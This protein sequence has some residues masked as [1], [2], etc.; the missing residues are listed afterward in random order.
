VQTCAQV[1]GK[2]GRVGRDTATPTGGAGAFGAALRQMRQARGLT[3]ATVARQAACSLSLIR[4]V[5]TG[6]RTIHSWLA[7]C[8]DRIYGTGSAISVMCAAGAGKEEE[9]R[10]RSGLVL[11][12]Q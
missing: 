7:N 3:L 5:E 8:L 11:Q 10:E 9:V 12:S 4:S 1:G 2:V 6:E